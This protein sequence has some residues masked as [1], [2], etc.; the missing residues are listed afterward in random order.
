M[1]DP[2][3]SL[4]SG[5]RWKVRVER[6]FSFPLNGVKVEGL[7]EIF[8]LRTDLRLGL[9]SYSFP[10]LNDLFFK[11]RSDRMRLQMKFLD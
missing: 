8:Y 4:L 10:S 5:A 3:L 9:L 2:F 7:T 1:N 11:N 6:I